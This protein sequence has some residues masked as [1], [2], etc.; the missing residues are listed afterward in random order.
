MDGYDN[1]KEVFHIFPTFR[2][3]RRPTE[4]E[5]KIAKPKQSHNHQPTGPNIQQEV[6]NNNNKKTTTK[7]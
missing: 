2:V 6:N 3:D 1:W 4:E 5:K 7:S